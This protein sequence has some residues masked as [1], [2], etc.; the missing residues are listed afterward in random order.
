MCG[1]R[2]SLRCEEC[3]ICNM[4]RESVQYQEKVVQC[5]EKVVQCEEKVYSIRRA[6]AAI[7]GQCVCGWR[8]KST[9]SGISHLQCE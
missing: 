6:T 9:L 7:R 8:R 5:E 4:Q 1:L 3:H 2:E